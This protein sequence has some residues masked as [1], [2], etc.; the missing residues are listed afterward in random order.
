MTA[1]RFIL[2][3]MAVQAACLSI[4]IVA[5][6]ASPAAIQ[7][8]ADAAAGDMEQARTAADVLRAELDGLRADL[9]ALGERDPETGALIVPPAAAETAADLLALIE[10]K[11][12]EASQWLDALDAAQ[13][14]WQDAAAKAEGAVDGWSVAETAALLAAG[15]F[16]PAA[17]AVPVIRRSRAAFEGVVA[18][19]AAGGGPANPEA[20]RAAMKAVPGLKDR[21]TAVRVKIGDK[22]MAAVKADA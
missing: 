22:R 15:F 10:S 21:V 11:S 9:L 16:P 5:G 7:R 3:A 12:A 1:R 14:S 20:A 4:L 8:Q 19:M 2:T 13:R 6:C 17:V 18:S